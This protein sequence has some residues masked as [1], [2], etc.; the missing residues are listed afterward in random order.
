M[1]RATFAFSNHADMRILE[2]DVLA[3]I[4]D[5]KSSIDL[6][7]K[8]QRKCDE[9]F[10]LIQVGRLDGYSAWS[11]PPLAL[12]LRSLHLLRVTWFS[13][14]PPVLISR[15]VLNMSLSVVHLNQRNVTGVE[16]ASLSLE[17][18]GI[19]DGYVLIQQ[20][21][22]RA[23]FPMHIDAWSAIPLGAAA[24]AVAQALTEP[25]DL[26]AIP[27]PN[28]MAAVIDVHGQRHVLREQLPHFAVPAFNA[29]KP[30]ST[31]LPQS[32]VPAAAWADFLAA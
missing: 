24:K 27:V 32:L 11:E 23:R 5:P 14:I 10:E 25:V 7:Y 17:K 3:N 9:S 20:L 28:P 12:L 15:P 29:Y 6:R 19:D 13:A 8:V 31:D 18:V 16:L 22:N 4:D 26:H 30:N 2:I 21:P 1:F